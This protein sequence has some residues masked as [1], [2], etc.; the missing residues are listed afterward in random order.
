ML[1][2]MGMGRNCILVE[3]GF[4]FFFFFHLLITFLFVSTEISIGSQHQSFRTHK[5]FMK[6]L[7]QH[8]N[9][10]KFTVHIWHLILNQCS[11]PLFL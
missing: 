10:V 8:H 6:K 1:R 7:A 2:A 11:I 5:I 9:T 3:V 4:F